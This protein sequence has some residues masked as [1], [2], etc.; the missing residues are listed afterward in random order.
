MKKKN[1]FTLIE[2]L[3]VI[4]IMGILSTIA[5]PAVTTYISK[6]KKSAFVTL[7]N[8]YVDSVRASIISDVF[9]PPKEPNDVTIVNI[10]MIELDQ[11]NEQSPYGVD[12]VI[13]KSYV[14]VVNEGDIISPKYVY[15]FAGQDVNRNAIPLTKISDITEK[16]VTNEARNTMEVT[17]QSL[18]GNIAGN[19][20]QKGIISGL[21]NPVDKDGK[22]LDWNVKIYTN[23][24]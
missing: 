13:P 11:K 12:W 19:N 3:T 18:A 23:Q 20:S 17:V 16:S 5:I 7:A 21:K 14:A 15:Y 22:V 24:Q 8:S 2:L 1:G 4:V 10:D 6:S 9:D